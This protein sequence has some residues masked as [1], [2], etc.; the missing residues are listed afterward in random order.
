MFWCSIMDIL[1]YSK[2]RKN[3]GINIHYAFTFWVHFEW[4]IVHNKGWKKALSRVRLHHSLSASVNVAL[5]K[6]FLFSLVELLRKGTKFFSFLEGKNFFFQLDNRNKFL[7]FPSLNE[8]YLSRQ[9][10]Q[11]LKIFGTNSGPI[12]NLI[13]CWELTTHILLPLTAQF[14]KS[15]QCF[16]LFVANFG[17]HI[18]AESKI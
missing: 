8:K 9:F 10:C 3:C 2:L 12:R 16:S 13:R 15:N 7:I 18:W 1:N 4:N 11:C 5:V 17:V 6:R 14:L